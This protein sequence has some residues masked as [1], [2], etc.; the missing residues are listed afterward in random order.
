MEQA[1]KR[2]KIVLSLVFFALAML[3][4]YTFHRAGKD[5]RIFL[6]I[7]LFILTGSL[8][9][10][11]S[12]AALLGLCTPLLSAA[13]FQTPALIYDGIIMSF[14]C[15]M[16]AAVLSWLYR[17]IELPSIISLLFSILVGRIAICAVVFFLAGFL[18]YSQNPVKFALDVTV[19]SLP[20]III[21]LVVIPLSAYGFKR[22]TTL[23]MD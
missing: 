16:A 21:Q 18:G 8:L 14:E 13:I 2:K 5:V 7:Q 1:S 3:S 17:K 15:V 22:Y 20:G 6:P 4:A 9:L 10:P 11:I 19:N 12:L 23:G